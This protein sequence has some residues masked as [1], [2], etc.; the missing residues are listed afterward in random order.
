MTRE[1]FI[2][3]VKTTQKSFRQFLTALCCGDSA[4]ADDVAQEA[5]I[6]AFLSSDKVRNSD[7]FKSWIFK[8]G[9]N[10]FLN[11]KR[12]QHSTLCF[13]NVSIQLESSDTADTSFDYQHLYAAL[14]ILTP[15]ERV[16]LLLFYMENYTIKEIAEIQNCTHDAVKQRLTR[17]RQHLRYLLSTD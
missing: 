2:Y 3:H 5:Y 6:K 12:S 1:Q 11:H 14:E 4:L 15:H 7:S 10:T 17:G 8:I 16:A 9:Y 13:E